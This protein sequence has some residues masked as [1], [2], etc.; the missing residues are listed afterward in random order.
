MTLAE[1]EHTLGALL[2]SKQLGT[3]VALRIHAVLPEFAGE[4]RN[5]IGYFDPLLRRVADVSAGKLTAR[6]HPGGQQISVL[7]T[8]ARGRT[9]M[10]TLTSVPNARQSLNVLV[11]GNHGV[12]QLSGGDLWN[13]AITGEEPALWSEEIAQSLKTGTSITVG[14]S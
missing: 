14:V 3:P 13:E 4:L 6:Q 5:I 10:V 8:D 1:L 11:L 9:A 7:W 12:T 2:D